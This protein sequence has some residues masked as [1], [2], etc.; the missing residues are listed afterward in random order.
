MKL[1]AV[2]TS[3][4]GPMLFVS[5][6]FGQGA[7]PNIVLIYADDQGWNG[8]SV[9]M[10]PSVPDSLSDFY[11]TPRLEA[12]A[13]QGMRFS[14]AYSS[15]PVCSPSRAA[16]MTGKSSAQLQITDVLA[17]CDLAGSRFLSLFVGKPLS[18]PLVPCH[19][20][21]S[22]ISIA[23]LVQ[24]SVPEYRTA[25]IGKWHLSIGGKINAMDQGF[26][27]WTS[28]STGAPPTEDP[29]DVFGIAAAANQFMQ[30]S[31]NLGRP[32]L[33][34]LSHYAVHT[35]FE[36]RPELVMKY[37]GLPPGMRHSDTTFAAMTEDFDTT[38]GQVID[39]VAE[40][41][42]V[43]NTFIIYTSDNGGLFLLGE[44][45][46]DPLFN[47]KGSVYE[48][49]IRVPMI[50]RGPGVQ[51]NSVCHTPVVGHDLF[52]TISSLAGVTDPLPDGVEGADITPLLFNGGVLPAGMDSLVRQFAPDGEL[53]FHYPHYV[54]SGESP[55]TPASAIRDGDFKLI[56]IYGENGQENTLLLFDLSQSVEESADP[57]SV[58]NLADEMPAKV[59]EMNAKLEQWI[60][61][62]DASLAYDVSED[63][64]LEWNAGDVG[65]I[66]DGWRSTIDVDY[67]FRETWT[68]DQGLAEPMNIDIAPHP[69][70]RAFRFDGDDGMTRKFFHVSDAQFPDVFDADHS[71]SFEFWLRVDALV[72]EQV[73][74]ESG[75]S[76]SGLS[77]TLGDGDGDGMADDVRF[78][79]LG[80][81]GNHLTVT[82][83]FDQF[84]DPTQQF[85]HLVAV[86]SD[87]PLDRHADIY[88][89]G[90]LRAGIAGLAGPD[91]I[92]WDGFDEAGLGRVGGSELGGNGGAGDLPF[93]GG[94]LVGEIA[95]FRFNNYA[96]DGT[97][98]MAR[99][100]L[101][102]CPW[103][104]E[105]VPD[106][107]IGIADFMALLAEWGEVRTPCDFG[108]GLPGVGIE[109]FLQMLGVWGACP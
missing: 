16:L 24:Q 77:I 21:A 2:L 42:I 39:K 45:E 88:I 91:E 17:S 95:Q 23:E 102:G 66:A 20:P 46:N 104:C 84:A 92:D 65:D 78:R 37:E 75:D 101:V 19:M 32:F 1:N 27:F 38:V 11:R 90:I 99:F 47:A 86:F 49:G 5:V 103:D 105:P 59:I 40:L 30:D 69:L 36:A 35:P 22:E 25:L 98:V 18:P 93:A 54:N 9:Q 76:V 96:I 29:K 58:L 108:A 71:S 8:T 31:V 63:V 14:N 83:E 60:Q 6:G 57:D 13:S 10:D 70:G 68:L 73:L 100:L 3:A 51:A 34:V 56:R 87:D 85:T 50:V 7:P 94:N 62:T 55:R 81:D 44:D 106:G 43:D 82:T 64:L 52:T 67:L 26:D 89:N 72:Q 4:L 107:D 12:L 80:L 97:E 74:F 61:V 53:F 28:G 79:I 48:G 33:V 41:G 15:A 109:D